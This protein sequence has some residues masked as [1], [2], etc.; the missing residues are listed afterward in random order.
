MEVKPP[1][2]EQL[3]FKT[4]PGFELHGVFAGRSADLVQRYQLSTTCKEHATDVVEQYATFFAQ[5]SFN[6]DAVLHPRM[7]DMAEQF[8]S[9]TAEVLGR[10]VFWV[11]G[12]TSRSE[13]LL[14][15]LLEPGSVVAASNCESFEE[16][17]V[18]FG[19]GLITGFR[20]HD[21]FKIK[22]VKLHSGNPTGAYKTKFDR[23]RRCVSLSL[24]P[25]AP[26]SP[27]LA[28][29]DELDVLQAQAAAAFK[30]T[31]DQAC[32]YAKFTPYET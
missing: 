30:A 21:D 16:S 5:L 12:D 26:A 24:S 13:D 14:R 4:F 23:D 2:E 18:K 11:L 7:L 8:R 27:S 3:D 20:V 6:P 25:H 15:A 28:F 29:Q 19:P 22:S 32:R 1:I 31:D 17:L 9:A 10:H